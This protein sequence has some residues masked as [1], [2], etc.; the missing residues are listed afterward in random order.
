MLDHVAD[1]TD[2][3][4]EHELQTMVSLVE[5]LLLVAMAAIVG[6]LMLA[7]YYP[8]LTLYAESSSF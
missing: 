3:E 2:E 5:P 1:F 7:I 6:I 8:L 4:I